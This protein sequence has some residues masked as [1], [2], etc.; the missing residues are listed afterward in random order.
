MDPACFYQIA[1]E[2]APGNLGLADHPFW[3]TA[4]NHYS[5]EEYTNMRNAGADSVRLQ[6]AQAGADPQDPLFDAE[7][8]EKAL[9]AIRAARAAGLTVIVC[10][11]D[12]SHV[13]GQKPID[14]QMT[15]RGESERGGAAVGE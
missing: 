5:P 4:Y 10:V 2:V 12:E 14:L 1:F 8:V 6:I 15:G 13:P 9:G 11:Q 7:F 3:A